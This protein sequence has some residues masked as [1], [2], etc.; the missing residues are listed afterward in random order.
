MTNRYVIQG[1]IVQSIDC[2]KNKCENLL[3]F[4]QNKVIT[5]RYIC[6]VKA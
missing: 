6:N 2:L 5:V 4:Q 1:T 3:R